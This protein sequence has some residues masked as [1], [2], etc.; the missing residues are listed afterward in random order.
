M[1]TVTR[2]QLRSVRAAHYNCE[3]RS[4]AAELQMLQTQ[5]ALLLAHAQTERQKLHL[6]VALHSTQRDR[7]LRTGG[8]W[9]SLA[10]NGAR[11]HSWHGQARIEREV[12]GV[13]KMWYNE[14]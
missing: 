9:E 8:S 6:L 2:L 11:P 5:S 10:E 12:G 3:M 14:V 1:P 4:T 7:V 13:V